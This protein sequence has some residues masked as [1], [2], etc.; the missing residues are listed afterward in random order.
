MAD[1]IVYVRLYTKNKQRFDTSGLHYDLDKVRAA[2]LM[3]VFS[4]GSCISKILRHRR[5]REK[6]EVR[7]LVIVKPTDILP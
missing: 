4:I 2:A 3:G 7:D 6:S 1:Y 5:F